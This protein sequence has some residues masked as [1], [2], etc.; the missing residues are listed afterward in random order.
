MKSSPSS[1]QLEKAHMQQQRPTATKIPQ[2]LTKIFVPYMSLIRA[3]RTAKWVKNLLVMQ[4]KQETL[5]P[6]LYGLDLLEQ[7]MATHSSI[8][9]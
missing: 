3:S 2:L 4:E 5:I 6:F 1:P 7:E 9:A 8:F